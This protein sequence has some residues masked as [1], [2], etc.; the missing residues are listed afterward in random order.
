MRPILRVVPF[1]AFV[2]A[3]A[4]CPGPG[5]QTQTA[6]PSIEPAG[7]LADEVLYRPTYGK[8]ELQRA[9]ITERGAEAKGES[10]V[11][12]LEVKEGYDDRLRFAQADLAV[13]RRFIASLE[14]CESEGRYC[15]PR[16]DDPPWAFDPDPDVQQPPKLDAPLRFDLASWQKIATELHG[17]ACA[18]RT[19]SCL[20]SMTVAI[21]QLEVRPM[22]DV[23]DV[24]GDEAATQSITWARE[25]LFRLRGKKPTSVAKTV[26]EE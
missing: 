22:P 9:L 2:V 11:A 8:A 6:E 24:Q 4:A 10:Q 3:S 15:P 7:H 18:C 12:E 16:L 17:R 1:L 19:Q 20:D 25:C 14:A 21:E 13:L 26:V 5:T 23:H